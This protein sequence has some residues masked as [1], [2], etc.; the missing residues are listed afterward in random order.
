MSAARAPSADAPAA[1]DA[2]TGMLRSS[3]A[4]HASQVVAD[5]RADAAARVERARREAEARVQR[6]RE[7]GEVAA[8]EEIARHD[9]HVRRDA[10]TTVLT[11]QREVLDTVRD[12][13]RT[14][15]LALRQTREYPEIVRGLAARSRAQ[16]GDAA[17]VLEDPSDR[18]GAIGERDGRRVDNT[19]IALADRAF[20]AIED[21]LLEQLS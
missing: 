5:A 17:T 15:V 7:Q 12:R 4:R 18:G 13:I 11:A 14:S 19:L 3:A 21:R 9:A 20:D 16:L 1:L 8:A 2:L 10:A 6:A